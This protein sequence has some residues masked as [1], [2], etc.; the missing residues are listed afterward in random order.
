[1]LQSAKLFELHVIQYL[2]G[3]SVVATTGAVLTNVGNNRADFLRW[4]V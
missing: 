4:A 1:M 2:S 3:V